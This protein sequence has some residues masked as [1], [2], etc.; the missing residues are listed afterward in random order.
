MQMAKIY[1]KS[2][3]IKP[4]DGDRQAAPQGTPVDPPKTPLPDHM[5]LVKVARGRVQLRKQE[6]VAPRQQHVFLP[7]RCLR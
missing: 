6:A 2:T 4:L 5:L 3:S 7:G 1:L